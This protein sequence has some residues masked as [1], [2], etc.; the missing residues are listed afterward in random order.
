[1]AWMKRSHGKH[2]GL[3]DVAESADESSAPTS[4]RTP[5]GESLAEFLAELL[6]R[7]SLPVNELNIMVKELQ[8]RARIRL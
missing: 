5:R 4:P 2:S 6:L 3:S 7:Y 8:V 1:M